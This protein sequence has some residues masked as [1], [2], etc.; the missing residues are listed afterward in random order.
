MPKKTKQSFEENL[1]RLSII[2]EQVEDVSTPLD[3]AI[4]LYKEGLTLAEKCG[5]T[6]RVHEAEILT[7]QKSAVG[8]FELEPFTEG[9]R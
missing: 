1:E 2:V 6:L 4:A 5:E 8:L 7:L 3:T 9:L